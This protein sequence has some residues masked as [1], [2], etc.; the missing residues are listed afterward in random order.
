M[1]EEISKWEMCE[2]HHLGGQ[3]PDGVTEHIDHI[4]LGH[5]SCTKC[6][7]AQFTWVGFCDRDGKI[8]TSN[9]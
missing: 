2:C 3:S 7:C 8:D 6:N 5:G 1:S 4:Q 9:T